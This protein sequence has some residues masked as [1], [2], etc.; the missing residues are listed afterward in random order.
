MKKLSIIILFF[1][2]FLNAQTWLWSHQA[3][4]T[5]WDA[6]TS[7]CLDGNGNTYLTGYYKSNLFHIGD[8]TFYM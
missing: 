4:G 1:P 2:V 3:G 7:T 8:E 5:N 6:E